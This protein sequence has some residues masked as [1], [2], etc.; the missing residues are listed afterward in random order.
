MLGWMATTVWERIFVS[1]Y[2]GRD[3]YTVTHKFPNQKGKG[4]CRRLQMSFGS[5]ILNSC[6][7]N[8]G[9]LGKPGKQ[10]TEPDFQLGEN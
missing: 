3:I 10:N 1:A 9:V 5:I 2:K 8:F 6:V 4:S 7:Q